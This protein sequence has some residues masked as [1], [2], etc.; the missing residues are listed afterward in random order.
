ML[1]DSPEDT[2]KKAEDVQSFGQ[3]ESITTRSSP[4]RMPKVDEVFHTPQEMQQKPRSKMDEV[5]DNI[6]KQKA[7]DIQTYVPI[8]WAAEKFYGGKVYKD[9]QLMDVNELPMFPT[10]EMGTPRQEPMEAPTGAGMMPGEASSSNEIAPNAAARMRARMRARREQEIPK[11]ELIGPGCRGTCEN[12]GRDGALN[13]EACEMRMSQVEVVVARLWKSGD[14]EE[15]IEKKERVVNQMVAKLS[16][17]SWNPLKSCEV[18]KR[19]LCEECDAGHLPCRVSGTCVTCPGCSERCRLVV[20]VD[21]KEV[22]MVVM[23]ERSPTTQADSWEIEAS[24]ERNE[25][26][27]NDATGDGEEESGVI[28][29]VN[30]AAGGSQAPMI[31]SGSV[32]NACMPGY[33][34]CTTAG[35]PTRALKSVTGGEVKHFGKAQVILTAQTAGGKKATLRTAYEVTNVG[36]PVWSVSASNGSGNTVWFSSQ[37]AGIPKAKDVTIRVKGDYL[38]LKRENGVFVLDARPTGGE[39]PGTAPGNVGAILEE[40]GTDIGGLEMG[41]DGVVAY[42][43]MEVDTVKCSTPDTVSPEE[44]AKHEETCTP[45]RAW[46]PFCVSGQKNDLPHSRQDDDA[47]KRDPDAP[48]TVEFDYAFPKVDEEVNE[49]EQGLTCLVGFDKESKAI[50]AVYAREKGPKDAY[51]VDCVKHFFQENARTKVVTK[52]DPEPATLSLLEKRRRSVSMARSYDHRRRRAKGPWAA[53][54]LRIRSLKGSSGRR[55]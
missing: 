29:G 47:E 14:D 7:Y 4:A 43:A 20:D 25:A 46:C 22:H 36:R 37:G 11:D 53:Q 31:D 16:E 42:D 54:R 55:T 52:T 24:A 26:E 1:E 5:I 45:Y 38:P 50:L 32:V 2:K 44:R 28:F 35:A 18:C 17:L 30:E 23:T 19:K 48:P 13:V 10:F 21:A 3:L 39:K 51:Q 12:C 6:L 27:E 33:G 8:R 49:E 15:I 9:G 41:D 40:P 34:G